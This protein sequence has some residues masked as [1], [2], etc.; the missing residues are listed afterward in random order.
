MASD[1]LGAHSNSLTFGTLGTAGGSFFGTLAA[2]AGTRSRYYVSGVDIVVQAGTVDVRVLSGT[3]IQGT[4]VLAAGQFVPG[5]GISK[6]IRPAFMSGP[7]SEL[8][9]HFVGAGTAFI[10]INYTKGV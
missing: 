7:N 4:G 3:A 6:E 5:G 2:A 9:Y 8:T 1:V 10:T